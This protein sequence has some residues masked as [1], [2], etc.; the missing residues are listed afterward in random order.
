MAYDLRF[1]L[2]AY[3]DIDEH[4]GFIKNHSGPSSAARWRDRL[5]A[6]LEMLATHPE[7]YPLAHEAAD[8]SIELREMLFGRKR[9]VYRILFTIDGQTVNIHRVR[10]SAQDRLAP[11]D[12]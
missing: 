12:I 2:T 9:H 1:R 3:A 7:R 11:G 8:L 4:F 10:H 5:M 6:R